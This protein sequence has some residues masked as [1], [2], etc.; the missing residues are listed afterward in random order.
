MLCQKKPLTTWEWICTPLPM[1]LATFW[2]AGC[3]SIRRHRTRS[4]H[5]MCWSIPTIYYKSF[6]ELCRVA[7]RHVLIALPNL[8][9]IGG[10]KRFFF[11]QPISAKYGLPVNPPS[12]RHRW[13]FSFQEALSFAHTMATKN[14]FEVIKEGCLIGPRRS[15]I[16]VRHL[17]KAFPNLL[18]PAY[19]ALLRR[20]RGVRGALENVRS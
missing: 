10:R 7:R 2:G 8:Y 5:W 20:N 17:V 1:S 16:G 13:L 15:F 6:A 11:G 18:A 3:L 19:V 9:D 4:L 14:G 12:D